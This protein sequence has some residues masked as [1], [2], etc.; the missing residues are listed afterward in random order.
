MLADQG[1]NAFQ[2]RSTRGKPCSADKIKA[3]SLTV[4]GTETISKESNTNNYQK[5]TLI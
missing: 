4:K 2:N 5:H 3:D 1:E